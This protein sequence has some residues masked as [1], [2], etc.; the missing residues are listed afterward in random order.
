M[1]TKKK[2]KKKHTHIEVEVCG[3][4]IGAQLL[5]GVEIKRNLSPPCILMW[6]PL[7]ATGGLCQA[8]KLAQAGSMPCDGLFGN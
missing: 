8:G 6:L 5:D 7:V 4:E 2:K 3:R 1:Y